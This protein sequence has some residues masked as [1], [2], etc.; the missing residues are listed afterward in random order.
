MAHDECFM[1]LGGAGLV[2]KQIAYRIAHDLAPQK[3][4]IA[5]LWEHEQWLP[6]A[7]VQLARTHYAAYMVQRS[8]GL[9]VISLNTDMCTYSN[10]G[11][12]VD[13]NSSSS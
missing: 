10:L 12:F 8:D 6:E 3:I 5:S 11:V 7:A 2:G 13:F 1:I 9:R 4:I